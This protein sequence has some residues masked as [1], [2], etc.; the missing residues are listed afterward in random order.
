MPALLPPL[1][2]PPPLSVAVLLAAGR[3][4]SCRYCSTAGASS[5]C[6][7]GSTHTTRPRCSSQATT[8]TALWNT[9]GTGLYTT[10]TA[11]GGDSH[12][13]LRCWP[14]ARQVASCDSSSELHSG[15]VKKEGGNR[16]W[17]AATEWL[18]WGGRQLWQHVWPQAKEM[19]WSTRA[20]F[21]C[22][23]HALPGS[24]AQSLP[25][26]QAAGPLAL[27]L[28][29]PGSPGQPCSGKGCPG[30]LWR[31]GP[32][33]GCPLP[34]QTTRHGWHSHALGRRGCRCHPCLLVMPGWAEA[35]VVRDIRQALV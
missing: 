20:G 19:R 10:S 33:L 15:A 4:P 7:S 30:S 5:A 17:V 8:R 34:D 2:L 29:L 27:A 6:A 11:E 28:R 13:S 18:G 35:A 25:P 23:Q 31:S 12:C 26:T 24:A 9:A 21:A 1:P 22:G 16:A 3:V 32:L 14:E